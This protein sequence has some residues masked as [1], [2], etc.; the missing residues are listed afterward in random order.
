MPAA[1]LVAFEGYGHGVNMLAPE[2]CVEEVR[3]FRSGELALVNRTRT[4]L[5][6]CGLQLIRP[7]RPVPS[8]LSLA[9]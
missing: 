2:R 7:A 3:Q 4:R 8:P 6:E 9:C 1:K 5:F